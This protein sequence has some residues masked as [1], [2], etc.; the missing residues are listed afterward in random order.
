MKTHHYILLFSIFL[1][2]CGTLKKYDSKAVSID[3]SVMQCPTLAELEIQ[4]NSLTGSVEWKE[5]WFHRSIPLA[6]RKGN[7]I[8][9]LTAQAK[10]DVLVEPRFI[11]EEGDAGHNSRKLSVTG[12]PATFKNFR[13][14]TPADIELLNSANQA[15]DK[16]IITPYSIKNLKRGVVLPNPK[17]WLHKK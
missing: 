4:K 8:A 11:F 3:C 6:I 7:L 2:S 14:A 15:L 17:S 16:Q 10:A 13:T 5:K 1:A 9:E 12:Y